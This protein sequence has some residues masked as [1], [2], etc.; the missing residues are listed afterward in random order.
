MNRPYESTEIDINGEYL[1]PYCALRWCHRQQV[2]ENLYGWVTNSR[3]R[4]FRCGRLRQRYTHSRC[5]CSDS[6][7]E[8]NDEPSWIVRHSFSY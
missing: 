6:D 4:C 5:S 1:K 3:D 2:E 8:W 7:V